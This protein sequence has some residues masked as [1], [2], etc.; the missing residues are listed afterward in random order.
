MS[1]VVD[2]LVVD[3]PAP[4]PAT[5]AAPAPTGRGSARPGPCRG[6]AACTRPWRTPRR[7]A[8]GCSRKRRTISLVDR[9]DAQREV[10]REHRRLARSARWS[11]GPGRCSPASFGHPLLGAGRA[12][13]ELPL[14]AEQ[15]LEEAV[16]PLRRR[17]RPGDLEAAGDRVAA[18]AAAE[19]CSSSPGPAARAG[20]PPAPGRRS[21]RRAPAPWVLPK[22]WPPAMSA[23][24]SSSFI[25]IRRNVSRMSRAAA[26]GSGLPF[27]P[28]GLT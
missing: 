8:S 12:L 16:V 2:Q 14:V 13:G 24:V 21:R 19:A 22:V 26:S 27:G 1:R 15:G 25:A 20:R 17:R 3:R 18:L 10:G 9:V 23:T 28:S 7:T 4:G 6:A 5:A 11:P